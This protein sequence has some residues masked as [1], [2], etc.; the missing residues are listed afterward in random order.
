MPLRNLQGQINGQTSQQMEMFNKFLYPLE[1]YHR[2]ILPG[3]FS[4]VFYLYTGKCS[5]FI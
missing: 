3:D 5:F 1:T 4:Q 2:C